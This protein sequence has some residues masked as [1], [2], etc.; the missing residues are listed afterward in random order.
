MRVQQAALTGESVPVEKNPE[1]I[2]DST[3]ALGDRRN[4]V[5]PGT[6]VAADKVSA[7][8]VGTAMNTELGSI[9]DLLQHSRPEPT[10]LQR[11]LTNLGRVLVLVCLA[12]V[13]VTALLQ[14]ARGREPLE[15]FR[16]AV[17]AVPEALP[18]VVTITLAVSLQRMVKRHTMIRT[19]ASV[20]TLGSMTVICLDRTGTLN[21][22]EMT[23][24][25]VL[26]RGAS[27]LVRRPATGLRGS[28]SRSEAR[29]HP[30]WS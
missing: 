15:T 11:R 10:L 12:V 18:A 26:A 2:L 8:V 30:A 20:E 24:R 19:L 9:A 17:A 6:M 27:Y 14:L 1:C 16:L 13:G 23:F 28:S 21:R 5:Y 29:L 25:E 3:T 7:V 22:N 4:M